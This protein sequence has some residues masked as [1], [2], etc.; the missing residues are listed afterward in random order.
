M[1]AHRLSTVA[2]ADKIY[3][4]SDGK[5]AESGGREQLCEKNGLFAKMWKD[6]QTSIQWKVSREV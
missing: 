5:I 2:G 3:V 4:I 1:I 6:Y